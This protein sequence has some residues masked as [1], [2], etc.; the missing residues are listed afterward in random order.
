MFIHDLTDEELGTLIVALK[1][2]RTNRRNTSV[3]RGD[4]VLTREGVDLLLAKLEIATATSL[5]PDD[6]PR[7]Y[8]L[9]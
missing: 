5:P 6:F 7:S 2:W 1:Y 3:R 4:A 8:F 9:R